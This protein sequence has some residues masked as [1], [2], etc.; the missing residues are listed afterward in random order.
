MVR[1]C[2]RVLS[3]KLSFH[4]TCILSTS[5]LKQ[6]GVV[7]TIPDIAKEHSVQ[8]TLIIHIGTNDVE[9]HSTTNL[10]SIN[11]KT[12]FHMQKVT[13]IIVTAFSFANINGMDTD[14]IRR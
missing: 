5:G 10:F 14:E 2:G 1:G 3:S 13:N 4:D 6:N 9:Q 11:L 7:S 8:D 12:S